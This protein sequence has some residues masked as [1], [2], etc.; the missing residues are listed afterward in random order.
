MSPALCAAALVTIV[1]HVLVPVVVISSA[2]HQ[3]QSFTSSIDGAVITEY[4]CSAFV[5]DLVVHTH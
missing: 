5:S 3:S 1:L 2:L 4:C